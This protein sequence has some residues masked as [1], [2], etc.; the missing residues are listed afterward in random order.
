SV[1]LRGLPLTPTSLPA[2]TDHYCTLPA[3]PTR[4]SSD[5]VGVGVGGQQHPPR[6]RVHVHRRL[7]ELHPVHLRHPVVGEDGA[8]LVTPQPHRSEEH[9]SELQS[10][11]KLVCRLLLEKKKKTTPA[12]KSTQ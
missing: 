6:V 11:E 3:L 7:Q 12:C 2:C 5:L 1:R 10:R 8:D 4:R 9:T